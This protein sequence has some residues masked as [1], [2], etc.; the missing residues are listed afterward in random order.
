MVLIYDVTLTVDMNCSGLTPGYVATT[1]TSDNWSCATYTL[2][3]SDG[4]GVW[5]GTFSLPSGTFEYIY[6]IDRWLGRN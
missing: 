1:G 4:D 6:I 3:D 5:E 2:T